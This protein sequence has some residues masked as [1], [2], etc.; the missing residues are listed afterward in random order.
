MI[1]EQIT[2][3][4]QGSLLTAICLGINL[5]AVSGEINAQDVIEE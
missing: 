3:K 5:F 1:K 4:T 2:K